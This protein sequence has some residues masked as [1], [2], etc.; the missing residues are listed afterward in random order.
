MPTRWLHA[1]A[2]A[3]PARPRSTPS[4]R[5]SAGSCTRPPARSPRLRS[6]A[7]AP[8][9]FRWMARM[10]ISVGNE[11]ATELGSDRDAMLHALTERSGVNAYLRGNELTLDGEDDA[12]E[13]ARSVVDELAQLVAQGVSVGPQTVD[14]VTGV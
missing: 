14:A 8:L 2:S 11:L 13:Q 12:V 7:G 4:R 10:Q 9:H 3:R 1:T 6:S 5:A